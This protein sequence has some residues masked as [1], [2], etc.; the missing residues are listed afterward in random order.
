MDLQRKEYPE[1]RQNNPG[2][3]N[4]E[5]ILQEDNRICK[6]SITENKNSNECK[7]LWKLYSKREYTNK[8]YAIVFGRTKKSF[9]CVADYNQSTY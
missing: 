1:N 2:M 4:H 3:P 7:G 9:I 8:Y 5:I 6:C